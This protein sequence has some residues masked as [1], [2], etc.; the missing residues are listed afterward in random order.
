[1]AIEVDEEF[2]QK[3]EVE[4]NEHKKITSCKDCPWH[5]MCIEPPSMT[6]EE[7]KQKLGDLEKEAKDP[8]A[9]LMGAMIFGGKDREC[10][11]CPI[12]TQRLQE[13]PKLAQKIKEI[14]QS[15]KN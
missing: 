6:E 3:P 10:L 5:K 14:M 12:F 4:E 13:S 8:F 7:I 15:W 1:M 9:S 11:A 2:V